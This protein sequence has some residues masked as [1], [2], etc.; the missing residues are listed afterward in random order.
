MEFFLWIGAC[1]VLCVL[2]ID[3]I[4]DGDGG[5]KKKNGLRSVS[6][7]FNVSKVVRIRA[8]LE[9]VLRSIYVLLIIKSAMALRGAWCESAKAR[10]FLDL[11]P[12]LKDVAKDGG[13]RR[14]DGVEVRC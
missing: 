7:H 14:C 12:Y 1:G 2:G 5:E 4:V 10:A 8:D 13:R 6:L 11:T 3:R 9:R